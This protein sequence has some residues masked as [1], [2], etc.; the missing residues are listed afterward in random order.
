MARRLRRRLLVAKAPAFVRSALAFATAAAASVLAALSA[1]AVASV[2]EIGAGELTV[3]E[4]VVVPAG[5]VASS[6]AAA[7]SE[8]SPAAARVAVVGAVVAAV[9]EAGLELVSAFFAVGRAISGNE[10]TFSGFEAS[11]V[12]L[13]SAGATLFSV[14]AGVTAASVFSVAEAGVSEVA[15]AVPE[16]SIFGT[17]APYPYALEA[18]G[19]SA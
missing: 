16:R 1:C 14:A 17:D 6:L 2:P 10:P 12:F 13:V 5:V 18:A 19:A 3:A 4:K 11:S 15:V 9:V 8:L 7:L